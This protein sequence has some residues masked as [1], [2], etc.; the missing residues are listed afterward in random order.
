MKFFRQI[1]PIVLFLL[2]STAVWAQTSTPAPSSAVVLPQQFAGWQLKGEVTESPDPVVADQTNAPV[3]K[4]YGFQRLEKATYTREDGGKLDIKAAV[5]DDASGSYGAFTYYK[6]PEMQNEKIGGQASS[7]GN[8]VLFYE[9]N[10][11]VDAVFDKL[12]VMSA[13]ELRELAGLLPQPPPNARNLP[14]LPTYLP[15]SGYRKNTAKYIMGPVTLDRIGAPLPTPMVDFQSGAEVVIGKYGTSSGDATLMLISYPTP[16][17]AIEKLRQ[18]NAAHQVNPPPQQDVSSIIKAGDFFD[19]RSGPIIAIA[20]GPLSQ[21]EANALLS[22]ISYQA[23]VTWNE[24]TFLS[25]KNNV[26]NF[27]FNAILLCFIVV[28]CSLV[29]G[30]AFGGFRVLIKRLYPDKVFDRPEG[31]EIISLHLDEK[32]EQVAKAVSSSIKAS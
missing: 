25:K 14:P 30:L 10:I 22:P 11:L 29:G 16:Q 21:A 1:L 5:F 9:T 20:A 27:L 7:F 26:A 19:K 3:L 15:R 17:I 32:V 8:R 13:A 24:N 6:I 4:E 31:L 18:I 2:F 23:D 12:T 28:G